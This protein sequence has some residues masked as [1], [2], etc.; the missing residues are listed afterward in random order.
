M[1]VGYA[2]EATDSR[3][4]YSTPTIIAGRLSREATQW[5]EFNELKALGMWGC[6]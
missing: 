5:Q 2:E 1:V 4:K 3:R 6:G